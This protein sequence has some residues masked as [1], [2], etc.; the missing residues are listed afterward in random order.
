MKRVLFLVIAAGIVVAAV[1]YR[2]SESAELNKPIQAV[3]TAAGAYQERVWYYK[4]SREALKLEVDQQAQ[5]ARVIAAQLWAILPPALAGL[6][7]L[8]GVGWCFAAAAGRWQKRNQLQPA[9]NGMLP[10]VKEQL[11]PDSWRY[12]DTNKIVGTSATFSR[13]ELGQR[14]RVDPNLA[15]LV[16]QASGYARAS[17]ALPRETVDRRNLR[18]VLRERIIGGDSDTTPIQVVHIAGD[19]LRQLRLGSGGGQDDNNV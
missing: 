18:D 10:V 2:A 14:E 5:A 3:S 12:V 16:E 1:I 15:T 4:Q 6:F 19:D 13:H 17:A 9:S 7:G 8:A 11:T